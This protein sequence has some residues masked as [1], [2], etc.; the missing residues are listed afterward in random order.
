MSYQLKYCYDTGDSFNHY[1]N[2][3]E[4][5]IQ[6]FRSLEVA[7]ENLKRIEEHYE[8]YKAINYQ[9]YPY[10]KQ[11]KDILGPNKDK[12]WYVEFEPV[13]RIFLYTDDGK[14]FQMWCPWCGHFEK[15]NYVEIVNTD[16]LLKYYA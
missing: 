2:Q 15:L 16:E 3:T 13:N 10:P 14:Q 9:G 8:Q 12:D 1:P 4:T 5:L 7:Q 11:R 6:E